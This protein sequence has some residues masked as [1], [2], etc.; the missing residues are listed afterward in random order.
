MP[1][2]GYGQHGSSGGGTRAAANNR[3]N[4]CNPNHAAYQG[5]QSGTSH[6]NQAGVDNRSNQMNPNNATYN[7]SRRLVGSSSSGELCCLSS[8][9]VVPSSHL[10]PYTVTTSPLKPNA[11]HVKKRSGT[12]A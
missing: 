9:S 10:K 3:S 2:G 4:Q 7:S 6:M 12:F 1:R 8:S 11:G 5:H